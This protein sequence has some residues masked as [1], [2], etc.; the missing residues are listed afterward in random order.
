MPHELGPETNEL[1][2]KVAEAV[3]EV[4]EELEHERSAQKK[5][6]GWL[7]LIG[8]STGILAALAAIAAMQAGHFANEAM[9]TEIQAA[10]QWNYFQA[11]STKRHIAQSTI[12]LLKSLDQ[13][14]PAKTTS[15]IIRLQTEQDQIQVKAEEL[16]HEAHNLL[17]QHVTF[18]RS[19]TALQ[20]SISLGAVAVLL[21]RKSVWFSSL[22]LA[23]VGLFFIGSGFSAGL[24]PV[25]AEAGHPLESASEKSSDAP[26]GAP[27][28][29][30]TKQ[31]PETVD[32][33]AVP[34][35]S[36][37]SKAH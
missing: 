13:T 23:M 8:L 3:E 5:E 9:L 34:S 30:Q 36:H 28:E 24:T 15:D 18:S 4:K 20:I 12:V 35:S 10:N 17:E 32:T 14:V 7:N 25:P 2:E 33:S 29:H 21:R 19:V 31:Q 27:S 1:Y 22:G 11:K 6:H 26:S 37:S 16:E